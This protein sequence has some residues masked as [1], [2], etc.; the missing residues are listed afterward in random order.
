MDKRENAPAQLQAR[1]FKMKPWPSVVTLG[2]E[3]HTIKVNVVVF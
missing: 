2:F 1:A 3:A